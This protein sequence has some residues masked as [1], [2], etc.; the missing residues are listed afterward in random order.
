VS[1]TSNSPVDDSPVEVRDSGQNSRAL[2][3]VL[4]LIGLTA[5]TAQIVLMREL[6]V[7]FC[8]NEMSLGLMLAS[9]LLWTAFGGS[10]LGRW[11]SRTLQPRRLMAVLEVLVALAFP[12]AIFLVRTSKAAFQSVPGEILGPGPMVLTSL[13]VLS[14]FCVFSGGLFAVGSQLYA[15]EAGTS[16]GQP[17][18][19]TSTFLRPWAR[20]WAECSPA[21]S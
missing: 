15:K 21:S 7:V 18:Q 6:M 5:V 3:P 16:R 1:R 8:G 19:A 20:A 10:A 17:G 4:V 12:L 2:P 14:A 13:V 9:W 11:A